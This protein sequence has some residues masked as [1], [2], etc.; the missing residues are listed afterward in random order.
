MKQWWT[1]SSMTRRRGSP[2]YHGYYNMS[3]YLYCPLNTSLMFQ[4]RRQGETVGC[5]DS[6]HIFSY[7]LLPVGLL[8]SIRKKFE[9]V[10]WE[11]QFLV[12]SLLVK[13]LKFT[14]HKNLC[15]FGTDNHYTCIL[16]YSCLVAS[17]I[18][19]VITLYFSVTSYVLLYLSP[20]VSPVVLFNTSTNV[21][22]LIDSPSLDNAT[23]AEISWMK[24]RGFTFVQTSAQKCTDHEWHLGSVSKEWFLMYKYSRK[25]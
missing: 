15:Q 16:S 11:L 12:S 4:I 20:S 21:F 13:M 2:S 1:G 24:P 14:T 25:C 3:A 9:W 10:T 6:S 8:L 17:Q 22:H 5:F 23:P 19:V 7:F 18:Y